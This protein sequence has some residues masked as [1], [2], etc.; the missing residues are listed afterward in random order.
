MIAEQGEG[1]GQEQTLSHAKG[2][3]QE[4]QHEETIG[5]AGQGGDETP[6]AETRHDQR[7]AGKTV[8]QDPSQGRAQGVTP[9]KG[10]AQQPERHV[11]K[12]EIVL[13]RG[14]HDRDRRAIGVVERRSDSQELGSMPA[15]LPRK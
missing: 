15:V 1:R 8:G 7:T 13:Q 6:D 9:E 14:K 5:N 3:P 12:A 2:D 11:G 10:S 4:D